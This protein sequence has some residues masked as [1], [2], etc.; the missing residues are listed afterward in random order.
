MNT[1]TTD[2]I[3]PRWLGVAFGLTVVVFRLGCLLTLSVVP[4]EKA[5]AF[6][7]SLLHGVDV[8]PILRSNIPLSEALIGI[9]T[10]F[11]LGWFAGA[12]IAGFYNLAARIGPRGERDQ[13]ASQ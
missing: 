10:T 2:I 3:S 5:V 12:M 8:G 4:H 7:N 13:R 6:F 11:V 1:M 9:I